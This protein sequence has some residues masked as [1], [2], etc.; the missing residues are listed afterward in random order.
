MRILIADDHVA[1]TGMVATLLDYSGICSQVLEANS[2]E[3]II[4]QLDTNGFDLIIANIK[5]LPL[6]TDTKI[7]AISS[8]DLPHEARKLGAYMFLRGPVA[9]GDL[10]KCLQSLQ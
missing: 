2:R 7:L 9:L 5:Y 6:Q 10:I 8:W 4:E 3:S 1:F